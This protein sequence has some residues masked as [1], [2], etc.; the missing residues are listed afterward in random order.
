MMLCDST[1]DNIYEGEIEVTNEVT[2]EDEHYMKKAQEA[3]QN[4]KDD[5][6]QVYIHCTMQQVCDLPLS[7]RW[8][9][10]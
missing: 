5:E 3:A 2:P 1:T 8:V 9:L 7:Y 6:T 4:S 10:F